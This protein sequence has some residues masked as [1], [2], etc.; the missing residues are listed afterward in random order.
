MKRLIA[1]CLGL[2]LSLPSTVSAQA[3]EAEDVLAFLRDYLKADSPTADLTDA[4]VALGFFDLNSDG[5]DEAFA[6]LISSYWCG[7]GGCNAYILSPTEDGFEVVMAASVT[8]TPIGVLKSEAEGWKD[9]FV[10]AGGGGIPF[11]RF[12]MRIDAGRY[13]DNPTVDGQR[14]DETSGKVLIGEDDRGIALE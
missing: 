2:V 12:A 3:T 11:G 7:S 13:P 5:K 6:Y 10:S 4:R 8:Q 14:I 1:T 9:V